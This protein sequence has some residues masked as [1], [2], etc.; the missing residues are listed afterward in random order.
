MF[1]CFTHNVQIGIYVSNAT[2]YI[3]IYDCMFQTCCAVWHIC[4]KSYC[5]AFRGSIL[6]VRICLKI[7][8]RR[9][10]GGS[11]ELPGGVREGARGLLE[12]SPSQLE[13]DVPFGTLLGPFLE[14]SWS[15]LGALVGRFWAIL[16]LPET[17]LGR[18]WGRLGASWG[19]LGTILGRFRAIF[20]PLGASM[21]L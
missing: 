4:F 3:Y 17:L 6:R 8:P 19:R 14:P 12:R 18:S 20:G 5:F 21:A 11:W 7:A 10:L 13:P 2:V 16:S 9:G 15:P 1:V